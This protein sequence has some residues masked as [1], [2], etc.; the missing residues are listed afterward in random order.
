MRKRVDLGVIADKVGVSKTTVHYALHQPERLGAETLQ[1]VLAAVEE[2]GYRPNLLARSLRTQRSFTLGVVTTSLG[3]YFDKVYRGVE[4]VSE[5]RGYTIFIACTRSD[6][7]RER[8][9]VESFLER[10]VEGLIIFPAECGDN[11]AFYQALAEEHVPFVF[12]EHGLPGVNADSV[13][14]DDALG[15]K[16]AAEHLIRH[17]R[18]KVAFVPPPGETR[19]FNW[20]R[21]R[22]EGCNQALVAAGL[23]PAHEVIV[24]APA[25]ER[26]DQHGYAVASRCLADG[27]DCDGVFAANDELAWGVLRAL[28]ESGRQP[29][30]DYA[31]VGF[32]DLDP[33]AYLDVPLTS[34]RHPMGAIGHEAFRLLLRRIEDGAELA[35]QRT[36]L[37]PT[38]VV[39]KS[40]G[41]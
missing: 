30:R 19:G 5:D 4:E 9:V 14:T 6:A 20:V 36:L 37:D 11:V 1:K 2:L 7:A 25:S 23:E 38:L 21:R 39:R 13:G 35:V 15:G 10:A 8:E 33:S 28:I 40:C 27:W 32:D 16:L 22:L 24:E 29:G 12:A 18:K 3:N 31:V 17:G 41:E 26:H 34:L